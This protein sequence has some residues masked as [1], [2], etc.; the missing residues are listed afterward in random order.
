MRI[1]KV[2]KVVTLLS[3]LLALWG[4]DDSFMSQKEQNEV[5]DKHLLSTSAKPKHF[6]LDYECNI[7][8]AMSQ[9]SASAENPVYRAPAAGRLEITSPEDSYTVT[10]PRHLNLQLFADAVGIRCS[11]CDWALNKVDTSYIMTIEHVEVC[12]YSHQLCRAELNQPKTNDSR[13]HVHQ[14]EEEHTLQITFSP[15]DPNRADSGFIVQYNIYHPKGGI[16]HDKVNGPEV[17]TISHG[18]GT[19]DTDG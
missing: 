4:C 14:E 15:I 6:F 13:Y 7:K 10:K 19:G 3:V 11:N 1:V 16:V 17:H 9:N 12:N 8:C 2:V 18:G 5:V